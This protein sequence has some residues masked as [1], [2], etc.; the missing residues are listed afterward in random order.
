MHIEKNISHI[1]QEY[2]TLKRLFALQSS[3]TQVFFQQQAVKIISQLGQN[4]PRIQF[5]FPEQVSW[6]NGDMLDIAQVHR[7]Q[8]TRRSMLKSSHM[9]TRTQL[10][11]H[12]DRLEQSTHACLAVSARLLRYS[13]AQVLVYDLIPDGDPV[14]YVPEA[15]DD[16]PSIPV[17]G[18]SSTAHTDGKKA[19]LEY[20]S[21]PGD[22]INNSSAQGSRRFFLPQ[23]VAL[24]EDDQ[25][26]T[27]NLAEAEAHIL[28]LQK[29]VECL[30]DAEAI[31]LSM[32]ADQIYQRKRAGLL[33]Q[34]VNQG[35]A[36]ARFYTRQII[37]RLQA[38]AENGL[39]NRGM[40]LN[41]PYFEIN[42]LSLHF[43]RIEVIPPGRVVF[44]AEFVVLA[45]QKA[46]WK[47]RQDPGIN[48]SSRRHLLA[49]LASIENAFNKYLD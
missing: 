2:E 19:Q 18:K 24:G 40:Q 12:L 37:L 1:S 27:A 42:D 28:S 15:D 31:C 5:D 13:L 32:V 11:K 6:G 21:Q 29:A 3:S 26:L 10:I 45:M 16:I 25:L 14:C 36:L 22:N 49:Q 7:K 47:V 23:W 39:L 33:G 44:L 35:R 8:I 30:Q 34:L 4:K 38:K 20:S 17:D 9:E 43:Y 48:A 46:A 41:L